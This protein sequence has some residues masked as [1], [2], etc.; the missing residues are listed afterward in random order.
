MRPWRPHLDDE[1][2]NPELG[3]SDGES[4]TK[5]NSRREVPDPPPDIK[6]KDSRLTA[7]EKIQEPLNPRRSSTRIRRSPQRLNYATG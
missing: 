4:D 3:V 6:E 2:S 5:E 7:T 1:E